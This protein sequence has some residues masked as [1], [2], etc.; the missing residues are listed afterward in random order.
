MATSPTYTWNRNSATQDASL[1]D[2][3]T[4]SLD[5]WTKSGTVNQISS[6]ERYGSSGSSAH[7]EESSSLSQKIPFVETVSTT[8]YGRRM[9][10]TENHLFDFY[11]KPFTGVSG[12]QRVK[13][14]VQLRDDSNVIQYDYDWFARQWRVYDSGVGAREFYFNIS[15]SVGW[16]HFILPKVV[17][18]SSAGT[19]VA[20]DWVCEIKIETDSASEVYLDEIRVSIW[21]S[22][23]KAHRLGPYTVLNNGRNYPVKYDSRS[24][25]VSELSMNPPYETPNSGLPSESRQTGTGDLTENGWYGWAYTFFNEDLQ[26]ESAFPLGITSTTGLFRLDSELASGTPAEDQVTLDFA[27]IEIPNTENDRSVDNPGVKKIL[28]Y[29]TLGYTDLEDASGEDAVTDALNNGLVYYEGE[30]DLSAATTFVST[31]SDDN[32]P[33]V[34]GFIN[35]TDIS[36]KVSPAYDTSTIYRNRMFIAGGPV[37]SEGM[38]KP[39]TDSHFVLGSAQGSATHPTNWNRSTERMLLQIDGE[40]GTYP[41]ERYIYPNDYGTDSVE[42]IYLSFPYEGGNSGANVKY[43]IFPV[44]SQVYY[45]E[46]GDPT[47]FAA[48]GYFTL[49]G[50]E[51][52][53]VTGLVGAG[54]DMMAMTRNSTYSFSWDVNP[55]D[56]GYAAPLSQSI[57]CTAPDSPV[58]IRGAAFWLSNQG[59]VKR[60]E[61]GAVEI[62]SNTLQDMFTDPEDGDYVVRDPV[63]QLSS[64]ARGVHYGPRQQYLL[65]VRTRN[66]KIGCDLVLAYNYFFES[67]DIFRLKSELLNWTWAVDD[68]GN[69]TLLFMDVYGNLNQWDVGEVDG[70]GEQPSGESVIIAQ[71]SGTVASATSTTVT[72]SG[73]PWARFSTGYWE[74]SVVRLVSGTGAGQERSIE[75]SDTN[76][77]FLNQEWDVNP[78][79]TTSFEIGGIDCEWNLK[80]SNL[81]L[82]SRVKRMK[83]ISIEHKEES[84]GGTAEVR[85]FK[86]FSK[87]DEFSSRSLA[88]PTFHTATE[89]RSVVGC[90]D[91]AGYNLRIQLKADGPQKPLEVRNINAVM[92]SMESD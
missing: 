70:G 92:E 54:S 43:K 9:A 60:D 44:N 87:E 66:A 5:E 84:I 67:W 21:A 19:D 12:N 62:I 68:D 20:E 38:C 16:T 8:L 13:V 72:A 81:G 47:N 80:F 37:F 34:I 46:E 35:N 36:R 85:V 26:E 42:Q 65:A 78:D 7:L 76:T 74:G 10:E 50:T 14:T 18:P 86:E 4:G 33:G 58:E 83:F 45:S 24:G 29:R 23:I 91:A 71:S 30:V 64:D 56:I 15:A 57:G 28:V 6:S 22:D 48:M 82:P 31:V 53:P 39:T 27:G 55:Y 40:S 88:V 89:P 25:T 77:L 11:A 59:V 51:G 1:S 32:L 2:W 73:T 49:D 41:I 61:R 17:A 75:K 90:S 69:D 79:T 63:T 3:T 52:E